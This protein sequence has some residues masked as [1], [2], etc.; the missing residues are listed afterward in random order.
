[1]GRS[2]GLCR[3]R[4]PAWLLPVARGPLSGPSIRSLRA[5]NNRA[6]RPAD[7]LPGRQAAGHPLGFLNPALYLLDGSAAIRDVPP[8]NPAHPPVV[9]GAQPGLGDGNGYLTT[10]GEDQPPLRATAGYDDETALGAPGASFV[11]AFTRFQR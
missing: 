9:I 1:M 5:R 6:G 2:Q 10:L 7:N 8:V 11:T 3:D 4:G